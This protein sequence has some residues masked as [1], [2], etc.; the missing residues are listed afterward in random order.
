[1]SFSNILVA[2][3]GSE[4][5][6]QAL[7]KVKLMAKE[8]ANCQVHILVVWRT[9]VEMYNFETTSA[10]RYGDLVEAQETEAKDK[11]KEA[12]AVMEGVQ[13]RSQSVML[14][15]HPS[16]KIVE[17]AQENEIDLI[18]MGSRGLSG[19]KKLFLGSVSYNVVQEATCSVLIVK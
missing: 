16:Q 12:E 19:I 18:V 1:M 8:S 15:G 9:P 7:E 11:M 6:K 14:E 2:Y 5:S 3:D 10:I 13:D 4:K 17:Y